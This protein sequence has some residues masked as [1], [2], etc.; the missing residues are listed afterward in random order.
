M[1]DNPN[2]SFCVE[3][4]DSMH[5]QQH[6]IHKAM[7]PKKTEPH[8]Y[9]DITLS[10]KLS[11]NTRVHLHWQRKILKQTVPWRYDDRLIVKIHH[12]LKKKAD[13]DVRRRGL[14]TT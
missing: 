8:A 14:F 10:I 13:D 11:Q 12:A 6:D 3:T 2:K 4:Y 5:V 1:P 7:D 9:D